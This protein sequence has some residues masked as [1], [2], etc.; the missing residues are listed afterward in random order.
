MGERLYRLALYAYPR[1]FRRR[2]AGEMLG[3]FRSRRDALTGRAP[4]RG[5]AQLVLEMIRDLLRSVPRQ[6]LGGARS[7]AGGSRGTAGSSSRGTGAEGCRGTGAGGSRDTGAAGSLGAAAGGPLGS[8]HRPPLLE[9]LLAELRGARRALFHEPGFALTVVLTLAL[10]I[11]ASAAV[12]TLVDG[13]LLEPLPYRDPDHLV[14]LSLRNARSPWIGLSIVDYLALREQA[15][16]SFESVAAVVYSRQANAGG[17]PLPNRVAVNA[18]DGPQ[19][20]VAAWVAGRLFTTLGIDIDRGRDFAPG[21][22][23]PGS[24]PVVVLSHAFA[25]RV[26]GPGPAGDVGDSTEH[27]VGRQLSIEGTSYTVIGVLPADASEV[28]GIRAEVWPQFHVLPPGRRGPFYL[29]GFGRLAAGSTEDG[30]AR[31]LVR[32]SEEIFPLWAQGFQDRTAFLAATPLQEV[33]VRDVGPVLLLVGGAVALVLAITVANIAGLT[34][35]RAVGRQREIAVRAALGAGTARLARLVLVE[36]LTLAVVGG[37]LGT[38]FAVLG[39]EAFRRL[40]P[41][42]PRLDEVGLDAG[43]LLFAVAITLLS[44]LLIG[45]SP[46]TMLLARGPGSSLRGGGRGASSGRAAQR[47]RSGLVFAEFA[48][49]VPLLVAGGLLLA[50]LLNLQSADPGFDPE[51]VL[52]VPISLPE[53]GYPDW[54]SAQQFW[55]E[56][57]RTIGEVPGVTGAGLATALPPDLP[58]HFNNFDLLD[59]PVEAGA[60][61]PTAHWATVTPGFFAALSPTLIEG[62]TLLPSDDDNSPLVA[63]VTRAWAERFYP[64]ESALGKQ[65]IAGGCVPCGPTTVVGVIGDVRYTGPGGNAEGIYAPVKQEGPRNMYLVVRSERP[66]ADLVPLLRRALHDLDADL[67][68]ETMT[69][70]ERLV[71]SLSRPR[72]WTA[73]LGGFGVAA[74]VLVAVGVF[75]LLSYFVDRQRREIGVRMVLGADGGNVVRMVVG[76]GL[77]LAVLGVVAGM[78]ASVPL[79]RW[80]ES[81]LY[82]VSG[83]DPVTWG[84]VVVLLLGV[85]LA[86]CYLPARRAARIEPSR[87]LSAD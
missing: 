86:A 15:S 11:G 39:I 36:N 83:G 19:A 49:T 51:G 22:D 68:F 26:F 57:E 28:V 64:E 40:G 61:Q 29:R 60:A 79:T 8:G 77:G 52:A 44:G 38:G 30:V 69:M 54:V 53:A 67:P 76:R 47:L 59:Q 7:G 84:G 32:V 31:E 24:D 62:R 80:L 18:G 81:M 56:A 43:F 9:P 41:P 17:P 1:D 12:F 42:V 82:E 78:A 27:A 73:L 50:S 71:D 3:Y 65:M 37:A 58:A 66:L 6:H 23:E 25:E 13:V 21:E 45:L 5:R 46:L 85:A 72:R 34:L 48:L 10:G 14:Y 2:Y 16:A 74:M 55:Q 20:A 4:L 35:T 75:G 33:I 87:A 70:N 63:V